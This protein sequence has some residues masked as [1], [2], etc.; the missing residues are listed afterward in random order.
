MGA[1]FS[2]RIYEELRFTLVFQKTTGVLKASDADPLR[3]V[4][5]QV[6]RRIRSCGR[7]AFIMVMKITTARKWVVEYLRKRARRSEKCE[8][9]TTFLAEL[10]QR[11]GARGDAEDRCESRFWERVK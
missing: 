7:I 2:A 10:E 1:L 11:S 8:S 5:Y 3:R 9:T 6:L 4:L